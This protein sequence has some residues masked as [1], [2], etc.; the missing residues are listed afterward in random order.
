MSRFKDASKI[1]SVIE[2]MRL[3]NYPCALN[4][5]KINALFNG[6][7]PW[8]EDER[9][10]NKFFTNVNPLYGTRIAHNAR[11]NLNNAFLKPGNYFKVGLDAPTGLVPR[12]RKAEWSGVITSEINRVLK[13]QQSFNDM[14][15]QTNAQVVLHGLGPV[16]WSLDRENPLPRSIGIE[17]VLVPA[18]TQLDFANLEFFAIYRQWTYAELFDMTHGKQRDPGWNMTLVNRVMQSLNTQDLQSTVMGERWLMPEKLQEDLK[19]NAGWFMTSAAPTIFVWDFYFRNY[20]DDDGQVQR[21]DRRVVLDYMQMQPEATAAALASDAKENFLYQKNSYADALANVIHWQVGNCSNVAPFRYYS[22]RSLGFLLF[23]VCQLQ[24]RMYC[25]FSDSTFGNMLELFRNVGEDDRER[26]EKVDL[27]HMGIVPDGLSFVTAGER[28]EVNE[29]QVNMFMAMNKQLMGESSSTYMP[30]IDTGTQK[31]RTLGEAQIALQ[32]SISLTNGLLNQGYN[33]AVH[34][35]RESARRFCL[36]GT[37]NALALDFQRRCQLQG[38]PKE[39]L[40]VQHWDIEPERVLGGGNKA[41]EGM[42]ANRLMAAR[43]AYDPEAQ[44]HILRI[45]TEANTDDP[46]LAELLVP[47]DEKPISDATQLASLAMGTLMN[48]LPVQQ[49]RGIAEVDYVGTMLQLTAQVLA[50]IEQ[51]QA[52]PNSVPIRMQKIGGLANALEHAG[53]HLQTIA[54]DPQEK[55]I[56]AGL[57]KELQGQAAALQGFAQQLDKEMQEQQPQEG[58]EEAMK[59]QAKI[60]AMLIEAQTKAKIQDA[61]AEQKRE[62]KDAQWTNEEAR[63]NAATAAE[64]QRKQQM[65]MVDVQARL[66]QVEA[67]IA[68]KDLTTAAEI[69]RPKPST[70]SDK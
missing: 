63:R 32:S 4:R 31:E 45:Y 41:I 67:D 48:G 16:W 40:D 44:R 64:I 3:A 57:S 17:D 36:P 21:W 50:Q 18:Q 51:L 27:Y 10:S 42:Q 56:V 7:P 59:A 11:T 9:Q 33:R 30:E 35:Y 47:L 34:L 22:V 46:K 8:T 53:Q 14:W 25:R 39:V 52:V 66:A 5:T 6:D 1:H 62:H 19:E 54:Q 2:N 43:P 20:D 26:L 70:E 49:R 12:H 13:R 61:N 24:N 23:A 69:R 15:D 37:R 28:H 38:V 55:E 68:S 58:G 29:N 60:Q 65:S